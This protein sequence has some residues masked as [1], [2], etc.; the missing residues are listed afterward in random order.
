MS[1]PP[2]EGRVITFL[3]VKFGDLTFPG[4]VAYARQSLSIRRR[5]SLSFDFGFILF[6]L[7]FCVWF[8]CV[9]FF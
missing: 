8:G 4:G 3:G 2:F 7:F 6:F 1:P 9:C 5:C